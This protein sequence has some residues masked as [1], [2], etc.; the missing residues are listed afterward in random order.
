MNISTEFIIPS[1]QL[2]ISLN[3]EI[4]MR[5]PTNRKPNAFESLSPSGGSRAFSAAL[6]NSVID[7]PPGFMVKIGGAR[8]RAVGVA[9]AALGSWSWSRH[10]PS[11]GLQFYLPEIEGLD[12]RFT[13]L[14]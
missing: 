11:Q 10:W 4:M 13:S 7:M 5:T 9:S 8:I 3:V 2:P 14:K 1:H 6:G 12:S